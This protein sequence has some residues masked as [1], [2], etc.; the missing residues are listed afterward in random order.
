[1]KTNMKLGLLMATAIS[2]ATLPALAESNGGDRGPGMRQE[3]G[4][5]PGQGQGGGQDRKEEREK[6]FGEMKAK[7][8]QHMKQAQACVEAAKDFQD[9]R[10]CKPE[11]G[12]RQG[13]GMGGGMMGGGMGGGMHG[14]MHGESDGGPDGDHGG[15]PGGEGGPE[16][17]NE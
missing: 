9:L 17:S 7:I 14:G 5:G 6:K 13:G 4:G 3:Q 1:M 15:G 2:F 8:L 12:G 10:K 16:G 11:H